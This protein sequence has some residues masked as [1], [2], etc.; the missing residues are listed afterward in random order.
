MGMDIP[1]ESYLRVE[2]GYDSD[3][4]EEGDFVT[5]GGGPLKYGPSCCEPPVIS[6]GS[7]TR[8]GQGYTSDGKP[9]YALNGAEAQFTGGTE[10]DRWVDGTTKVFCRGSVG[11][12]WLKTYANTRATV[13]VSTPRF[14]LT[15]VDN[16]GRRIRA[17]AWI[18]WQ[19]SC[20]QPFKIEVQRK[21][22]PRGCNCM[23]LYA[24]AERKGLQDAAGMYRG[25]V[26]VTLTTQ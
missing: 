26:R 9:N 1:L 20:G 14:E 8:W 25:T 24:T 19:P 21:K 16:P 12:C 15:H 22:L 23:Y 11:R 7:I 18:G 13:T 3:R 2:V 4:M 10:S 17:A 5:D 6:V